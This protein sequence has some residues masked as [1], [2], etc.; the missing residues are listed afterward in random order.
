MHG[1]QKIKNL[2]AQCQKRGT[3]GAEPQVTKKSERPLK[4]IEEAACHHPVSRDLRV[5]VASLPTC[6]EEKGT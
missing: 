6:Q 5:L 2:G 1:A 3:S 4:D